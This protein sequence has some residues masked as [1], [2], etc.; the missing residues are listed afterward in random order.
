[1]GGTSYSYLRGLQE[2]YLEFQI[3]KNSKL[4]SVSTVSNGKNFKNFIRVK[5]LIMSRLLVPIRLI[6]LLIRTM[7]FGAREMAQ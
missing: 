7:H 4:L 6:S 2:L 1:M 5:L 3:P